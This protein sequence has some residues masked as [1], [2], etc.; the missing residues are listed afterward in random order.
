MA[1]K[2]QSWAANPGSL[3]PECVSLTTLL[4]P[5]KEEED[6][7]EC[8]APFGYFVTNLEKGSQVKCRS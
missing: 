7:F 2:W 1:W 8:G 6:H 3:T 4:S 5:E